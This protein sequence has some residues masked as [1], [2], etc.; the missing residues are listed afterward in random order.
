MSKKIVVIND[1]IVEKISINNV[2]VKTPI[3]AEKDGEVWGMVMCESK[4]WILRNNNS[5]AGHNGY[6]QCRK[7]LLESCQKSGYSFFV[8]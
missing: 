2:D 5:G 3:F 4:G 1:E 6:H 7:D 8:Y